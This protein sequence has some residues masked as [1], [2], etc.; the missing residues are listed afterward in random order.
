[1]NLWLVRHAQPVIE[2]GICYGAMDV[3]ADGPATELAARALADVLPMHCR[4][5]VSTLQRCEQLAQAVC[6]LRPDLIPEPERR[7]IEMNF[8]DWEGQCWSGIA[9]EELD[10]WTTDFAHWQCGGGECVQNFMQRIAAVWDECREI[11]RLTPQSG[12]VV[13]I[14]H[15]GVIRAANLL[16]AGQRRV[17]NALYWPEAAPVF[18][19]WQRINMP[20]SPL[21]QAEE[22]AT[23]SPVQGG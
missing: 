17:L 14:T 4:M 21:P 15:A 11:S 23:A 13:W 2:P 18:G 7:L 20:Y 16:A 6:G 9:R 8:G 5:R 19:N 10:A 22:G 12:S 3:S 1:M